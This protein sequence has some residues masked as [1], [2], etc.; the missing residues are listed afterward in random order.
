MRKLFIFVIF[1]C[2]NL[3][4]KS[5]SNSVDSITTQ[6]IKYI[7]ASTQKKFFRYPK[8]SLDTLK[9]SMIFSNPIDT[10]FFYIF[11]VKKVNEI[12]V[13][14]SINKRNNKKNNEIYI[15]EKNKFFY[16]KKYSLVE[17][18]EKDLL[19]EI[20]QKDFLVEINQKY[21]LEKIEEFFKFI[22][23]QIDR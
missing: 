4:A 2:A 12:F 17:I 10:N 1:L 15:F 5:Q 8:D 16:N 21:F 22:K 18:N 20:N 6:V 3:S 19:V 11:S 7:E 13:L 23:G 9:T 14:I